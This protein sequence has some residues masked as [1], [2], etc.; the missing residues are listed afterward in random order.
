ME[1]KLH[2]HL[3]Q[4]VS[5]EKHLNLSFKQILH[6]MYV[7]MYFMIS[8]TSLPTIQIWKFKGDIWE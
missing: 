1:F 7:T 8:K 2:V 6:Y 5:F 3:K 4:L